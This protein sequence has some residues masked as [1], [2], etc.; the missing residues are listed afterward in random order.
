[1]KKTKKPRK[2]ISKG[3]KKLKDEE[4]QLLASIKSQPLAEN[5]V[6]QNF[7]GTPPDMKKF[8]DYDL[9]KLKGYKVVTF[10]N[11]S[12]YYGQTKN[13]LKHGKGKFLYDKGFLL[14]TLKED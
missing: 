14:G 2:K 1:M 6:L 12:K 13:G 11:D 10:I 9:R 4:K 5:S 3:E 7:T 8:E